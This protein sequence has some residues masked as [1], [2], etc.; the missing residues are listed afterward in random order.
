VEVLAR[1]EFAGDDAELVLSLI[2]AGV[3]SRRGTVAP[4]TGRSWAE[5]ALEGH[6]DGPLR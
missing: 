6:H 1:W 3:A 2:V 5:L 4:E